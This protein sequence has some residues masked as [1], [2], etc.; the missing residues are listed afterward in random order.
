MRFVAVGFGGHIGV[1]DVYFFLHG[2]QVRPCL[3]ISI[4]IVLGSI[5]PPRR[6]FWEQS[7]GLL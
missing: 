7:R 1:G 2:L 3:P 4:R 5:P 6:G